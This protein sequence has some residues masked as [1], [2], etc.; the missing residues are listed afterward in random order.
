VWL[1][2]ETSA[3]T[4]SATPRIE[5]GRLDSNQ[6]RE[7]VRPELPGAFGQTGAV[8]DPDGLRHALRQEL[9]CFAAFHVPEVKLWLLPP[10]APSWHAAD[11]LALGMPYWAFA[12]PGG[13]ALAR[14]VLDHP[15]VV[16]G[17][18]VLDF[19]SGCAIEG[20]AARLRGA[21]SVL[22]ADIDPHARWATL[23]NARENGVP[24]EFTG[25]DL[26]G[27]ELREVDLILAGDV[28]YD[29]AMAARVLPWLRAPAQRG[30]T[31]LVGDPLRVRGALEAEPV[32]ESYDCSFDG[33][34]RGLT[35]WPTRVLRIAR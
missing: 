6:Q 2:P 29:D 8:P 5:A 25:E 9:R 10:D 33:D 7:R 28:C 17:Q 27:A 1:V 3:F 14:Y 16:R 15:E 32:L 31:V 13:A 34:P 22:C 20:V 11:P 4:N 26:I 21:R 19:G 30:A 23:A 35:V 24:L 18:R 12:W